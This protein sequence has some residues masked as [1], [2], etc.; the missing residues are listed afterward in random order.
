MKLLY[1]GAEFCDQPILKR[2][3]VVAEEIHFMDR[4][5]VTFRNWGTIGLATHTQEELTGPDLLY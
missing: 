5:S 1:S 2:L 3:L 4:P